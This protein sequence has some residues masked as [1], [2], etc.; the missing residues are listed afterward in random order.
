MGRMGL[1]DNGY[2]T[3]LSPSLASGVALLFS[4]GN[5]LRVI[6]GQGSKRRVLFR[7]TASVTLLALSSIVAVGQ[8]VI[9][10]QGV[11]VFTVSLEGMGSAAH[12]HR[13]GDGFEVGGINAKAIAA[14]VVQ[15]ETCRYRLDEDL[16][17]NL[18]GL[19]T[20]PVNTDTSI[21]RMIQRCGPFP[22]MA[23]SVS[24]LRRYPYFR[25]GSSKEY[26]VDSQT[27]KRTPHIPIIPHR[28]NGGEVYHR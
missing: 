6:V 22:A 27:S 8:D 11:P 10:H 19:S 24:S 16:V 15:L 14:Q 2:S 7:L 13:V 21:P 25:K 12:I 17:E 9:F 28:D 18:V 5:L 3:Q 1:R 20:L 4:I 23:R 26:S